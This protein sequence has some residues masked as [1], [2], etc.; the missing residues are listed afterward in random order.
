MHDPLDVELQDPVL[1]DEIRMVTHLMVVASQAPAGRR[2]AAPPA[3]SAT[4][5]RLTRAPTLAVPRLGR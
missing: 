2:T 3:R 4:P 1:S 5:S